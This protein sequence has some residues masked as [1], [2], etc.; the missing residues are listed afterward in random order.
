MP[1]SNDPALALADRL[2]SLEDAELAALLTAREPRSGVSDFFDLA[3]ALLEPDSVQTALGRLDRPALA[4]LVVLA[5]RGPSTIAEVSEA[6][7]S[8]GSSFEVDVSAALSL[9][10]VLDRDGRVEVPPAVADQLR[11]GLPPLKDLVTRSAPVPLAPVS[12]ADPRFA[13]RVAA[14]R[15]F[16][17]TTAVASLVTEVSGQPARELARGGLALPEG[18]RLATAMRIDLDALPAL[19]EVATRAE[20]VESGGGNL[21]A[22]SEAADWLAGSTAHRWSRLVGAWLD[23]LPSDVRSILNERSSG[24]WDDRLGAYI[25]WLFPAGGDR[26]REQMLVF[27][28]DAETLGI[29][30]DAVPTTPGTVLLNKGADAAAAAM[31]ALLPAEVDKV[32]LQHDLSIVAPGPLSPQLEARLHR[33]ADLEVRGLA[34]TYRV[35]TAS[36]YRALASGE[37]A[38]TIREFLAGISLTGLPQPLAYLLSEAAARYG[39]VRV[40]ADGDGAVVRSSDDSLLRTMLVDH[41]LRPLGLTR[42]NLR[43]ASADG[44]LLSRFDRDVVYWSLVAARYPAVAENA[45]GEPVTLDR[46]RTEPPPRPAARNRIATLIEKLR[47]GEPAGD[48]TDEAWMARQLDVAIRSKLALT[49]TVRMPD[50]SEHDYQLEPASVASGRLRARDRRADIERTL[51]LA[52]IVAVG[53]AR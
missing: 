1:A 29:T 9:A 7:A 2:R 42:P 16:D 28:R 37:T 5:D 32:Y 48:S 30:A 17:T 50:G 46:P 49:V 6:L 40:A 31:H 11:A 52:N 38:T 12:P 35:S 43:G 21:S 4:A 19:V 14:E 18:K 51:P 10:L 53:P 22:T 27:T 8:L 41:S 25:D 34:S 33:V 24:V 13:D 36:L 20:L 44:L 47:L 3:D 39:L 45:A 15:A 26:M 23:A